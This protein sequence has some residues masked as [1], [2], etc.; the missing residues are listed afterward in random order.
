[1][2]GQSRRI[3]LIAA[4]DFD[5]LI[6]SKPLCHELARHGY[7]NLYTFSPVGL[8]AEELKTIP[9]VHIPIKMERFVAPLADLRY[10]WRIYRLLRRG[11]F[12]TV[13]TFTTK[14]NI[15]AAPMAKLAGTR[16]IVLAVR[17]LGA[18]FSQAHTPGEWLVNAL[19]SRFYRIACGLGSQVWFTN[20]NDM[21]MF[22]S[23]RYVTQQKILLT[24]NAIDLE[25]FAAPVSAEHLQ[26]LRE[27]LKMR[28]GERAVIMVARLIWTKG[29]GEF[30]EAARLLS[31][32]MPLVRFL[33]VAPYEP[34]SPGTVPE[35]YVRAA[36]RTANFSW[37]GFR[38][39]VVEL[40]ALADLAVLPSYY[41]EGGYPRA[42]LEPMAQGKPVIAADTDDCRGPVEH[43]R[44]GYLIPPKN[45]HALADAI[46]KLMADRALAQEFGRRSFDK[47]R[48][49]FDVKSVAHQVL[50]RL[51]LID[52]RGTDRPNVDRDSREPTVGQL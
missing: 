21:E 14:P 45:V 4:A 24:R 40:Y 5:A 34:G 30:V 41:K 22:L 17:G 20:R 12:E 11:R 32:Q 3:A 18:T 29:V 6:F 13:I 49:E 52:G 39:D 42:L 47:V 25:V 43:G 1:M 23:R 9:G 46:A 33:L 36:E 48:A 2:A 8:Y 35:E 28:E 44:N 51:A 10:M 31:E 26:Q 19:S 37:L 16:Q 7:E 50:T 15:Y 27:E 38:K